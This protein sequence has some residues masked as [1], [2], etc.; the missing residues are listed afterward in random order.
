MAEE[1]AFKNG[2]ISNSEGL[3]TS[4]FRLGHIIYRRASLIDLYLHAKFHWNQRNF[5]WMDGRTY[6]RMYDVRMHGKTDR[7]MDIETG[8]IR[9]TL[10]KS[11]PK[12]GSPNVTTLILETVCYL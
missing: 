11:R 9:S 3:V 10:S 12:K 6:A 1:I 5:L 7:R 4:T 8:F 2:W